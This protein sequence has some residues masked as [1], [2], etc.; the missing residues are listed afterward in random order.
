VLE[1][2]ILD[3]IPSLVTE[4]DNKML[5]SPPNMEEVQKV[6]FSMSARTNPK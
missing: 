3:T 6:V 1:D 4:E 5:M 2:E